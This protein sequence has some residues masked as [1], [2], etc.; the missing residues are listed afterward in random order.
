[1]HDKDISVAINNYP[2][3]QWTIF[4]YLKTVFQEVEVSQNELPCSNARWYTAL[5]FMAYHGKEAYYN[6]DD[7]SIISMIHNAYGIP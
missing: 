5:F 7:G 3:D 1:M 4:L 6:K 2:L